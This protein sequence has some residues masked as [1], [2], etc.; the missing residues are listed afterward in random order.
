MAKKEP[1][2]ISTVIPPTATT[3]SKR[4]TT[5]SS[6]TSGRLRA[7]SSSAAAR[8]SVYRSTS[9]AVVAGETRALW[10][11]VIRTPRLSA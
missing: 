5:F 1:E 2:G 8:T 4:L 7:S 3:P 10:N 11:G 9:A 6:R